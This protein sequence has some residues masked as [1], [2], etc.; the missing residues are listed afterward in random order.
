MDEVGWLFTVRGWLAFSIVSNHGL[1]NHQ[2][3]QTPAQNFGRETCQSYRRFFVMDEF[4][5]LPISRFFFLSFP[6]STH[7]PKE[8]LQPGTTCATGYDNTDSV[9]VGGIPQVQQP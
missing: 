4:S 6:T 1:D 7:R 9:F 5:F 2:D 3:I 8:Q